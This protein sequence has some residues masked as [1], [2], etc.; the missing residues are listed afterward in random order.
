MSEAMGWFHPPFYPPD[1]EEVVLALD[2][3]DG[4]APFSVVGF[5]LGGDW[6]GCWFDE[7]Q[8]VQKVWMDVLAW[9]YLP[10][11]P[12]PDGTPTF[13]VRTTSRFPCHTQ[14]KRRKAPPK[15]TL[16]HVIIRDGR[17]HASDYGQV[18]DLEQYEQTQPQPLL[19]FDWQ[20]SMWEF[21]RV[22]VLD[23]DRQNGTGWAAFRE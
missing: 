8:A 20:N 16:A 22:Y 19:V 13:R 18:A 23:G 2:P 7:D 4:G 1:R 3:Q 15:F 12:M 5:R 11:Y 9:S 17:I 14:T 6:Y 10:Y 21:A